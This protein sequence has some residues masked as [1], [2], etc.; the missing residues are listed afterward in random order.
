MRLRSFALSALLFVSFSAFS[1]E[2]STVIVS[3]AESPVDGSLWIGT[4]DQGIFR[5]GRKGRR[6]WYNVEGG[7]LLSNEVVSL[8]FD[9]QK[10][11]WILDAAGQLSSYTS[12]TG[13]K[14]EFLFPDR[15]VASAISDDLCSLFVALANSS[16]YRFDFATL[17]A[18]E[19]ASLPEMALT[20]VP[21]VEFPGELW[22]LC[23]GG[24]YKV[25]KEGV[26]DVPD[27]MGGVTNTIPFNFDTNRP[28]AVSKGLKNT[29]YILVFVAVLL[30]MGL[31]FF[32]YRYVFTRPVSGRSSRSKNT[33][34]VDKFSPSAQVDST[35]SDALDGR[36]VTGKQSSS[37]ETALSS[38]DSLA[39]PSIPGDNSRSAEGVSTSSGALFFPSVPENPGEFTTK[40]LS[41][42]EE[43]FSNPDFD[44]ESIA[45]I[46][47]LSR[48][49]L[50]RK[51]KSEGS[52][53]PSALLKCTRMT[54]ASKLLDKGALTISQ[55][56]TACGF[57]RPS[58]FTTAFKDFYGLTPT[59]YLSRK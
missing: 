48:I 53:S 49:H 4:A 25:G 36:S 9:N 12:L 21:S 38:G 56:C 16:V 32:L 28:V 40:V 31:V 11:L 44:V 58:Y 10:V 3:R 6:A 46:V 30:F 50:N 57:A 35:S 22:A 27:G 18:Q 19:L 23:E 2:Q 55:I 14:Q 1:Q 45:S 33:P 7:Q 52:P 51:L 24:A 59:D 47:G 5:L 8:Q 43:N 42:I 20:L 15:V 54:T 17:G 29:L 39:S 26:I 13:F 34:V 37:P 41:I